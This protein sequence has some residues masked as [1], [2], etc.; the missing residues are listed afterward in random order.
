M[1]KIS[2]LKLG[3]KCYRIYDNGCLELL[4]LLNK[5]TECNSL[6]TLIFQSEYKQVY[7]VY[8]FDNDD[9][10]MDYHYT[11]FINKQDAIDNLNKI[12]K[13]IDE[14]IKKII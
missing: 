3:D 1:K 14:S 11:I 9:Y 12:K 8:Q 5:H 4:Y 2:D 6:S 13:R 10:I 7:T